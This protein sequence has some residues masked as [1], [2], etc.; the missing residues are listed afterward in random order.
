MPLDRSMSIPPERINWVGM[1]H[2]ECGWHL[3]IIWSSRLNCFR[4]YLLSASYGGCSVTSYLTVLLLRLLPHQ[5]LWCN[6]FLWDWK[7]TCSRE[8]IKTG[9]WTTLD[10]F[11]KSHKLT[12]FTRLLP[13]WVSNKEGPRFTLRPVKL[14]SRLWGQT[15]CLEEAVTS[16]ATWKRF[17]PT[18]SLRKDTLQFSELPSGCAVC[19]RFLAFISC[20]S[21][22]VGFG[23]RAVHVSFL[24]L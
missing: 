19:S 15:S 4:S 11:R 3:P 10:N 9:R 13:T 12:S 20:P 21:A 1:T 16:Q 14:Q 7:I 18:E 8:A 24:L 23:D 17:S 5:R 2:P 22:G 6:S